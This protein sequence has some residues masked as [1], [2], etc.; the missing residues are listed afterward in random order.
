MRLEDLAEKI[1]TD[2]GNLSRLERGKQGYDSETLQRKLAKAFGISIAE[3]FERRGGRAG[4]PR[5]SDY[6]VLPHGGVPSADEF[7][8]GR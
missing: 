6:I 1:G 4:E 3:L 7:A 8:A 2:T 5:L